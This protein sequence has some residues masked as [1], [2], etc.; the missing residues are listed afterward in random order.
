MILIT[1]RDKE[2]LRVV[3]NLVRACAISY[4]GGKMEENEGG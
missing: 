4:E 3:E 2:R 1:A